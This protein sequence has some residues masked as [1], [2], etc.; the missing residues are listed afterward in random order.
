MNKKVTAFAIL[1]LVTMSGLFA[2]QLDKVTNRVFE[3]EK[4]SVI[5]INQADFQKTRSE[6]IIEKVIQH[7]MMLDTIADIFRALAAEEKNNN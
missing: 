3:L 7:E 2:W 1:G 5:L 4:T 6:A